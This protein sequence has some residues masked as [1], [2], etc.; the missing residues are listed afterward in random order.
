[1]ITLNEIAHLASVSV[2]TVDRVIHD[3]GRVSEET[4]KRVQ[5][6]IDELNYKPNV[7][8]R[9]L[10]LKKTYNFG[11]LMPRPEQDGR[12]WEL[13]V[14]GIEKAIDEIKMYNVEVSY[15]FYDKYSETSFREV[16]LQVESS[17]EN[18][19]GLVIAPVRSKA[20]EKFVEE[21]PKNLPF[22]FIDSYIR[23]N[24][25]LSYIGQESYQSGILAAKLMRLK[26]DHGNI[27]TMRVLPVDYHI[28]DRVKG[29]S[30]SIKNMD[31]YHLHVFDADREKDLF[32]FRETTKRILNEVPDIKGI[33]V[34]SSCIHQVADFLVE[35]H[36]ERDIVLIGYDLVEDNRKHLKSG[37]IDFVISQR[38]ALQGYQGIISLFRHV[39]LKESVEEKVIV[40]MDILT[41]ENV[42]YYQ[43]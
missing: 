7:I 24:S 36:R 16:C 37:A 28:D 22:V 27:A 18:Y 15:L 32:I 31:A 30:D 21:L 40:P 43:G 39:I 3:R 10:S 42:D 9:N 14:N 12:Y 11:V 25:C 17:I 20:S 2:G 29:F 34:P 26:I 33:F 41:M 35:K 19:D 6:L 13:P 38:P 5:K 4:K 8:A 1:M 23:C